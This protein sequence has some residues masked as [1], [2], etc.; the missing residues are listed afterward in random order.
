MDSTVIVIFAAVGLFVVGLVVLIVGR[1][2]DTQDRYD[3]RPSITPETRAT[4]PSQPAPPTAPAAT[5]LAQQPATPSPTPRGL[6][7]PAVLRE[8]VSDQLLI[9]DVSGAIHTVSELTGMTLQEAG[10]EVVQIQATLR[11]SA[12]APDEPLPDPDLLPELTRLLAAHQKIEAIKRLHEATGW[13][14][15]ESKDYVEALERGES[16]PAPAPASPPAPYAPALEDLPDTVLAL[17]EMDRKIEAVKVVREVTGW[18]LKESKDYVDTFERQRAGAMVPVAP[19]RTYPPAR[20]PTGLTPEVVAE[21]RRLMAQHQKIE[22]I[23]QVRL[24][25]DM[26]LKDAKDYVESL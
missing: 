25:T 26:S 22:A 7:D 9:G 15:K 1:W 18:G 4:Y 3:G 17:L 6:S 10:R 20:T 14:L 16:V 23:K 13:G 12:A 21:V 2:R 11:P 5:P 19:P 24:A 8:K